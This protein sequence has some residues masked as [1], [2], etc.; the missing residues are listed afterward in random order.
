MH[1]SIRGGAAT[2]ITALV[3]TLL[4]GLAVA[5]CAGGGRTAS[6]TTDEQHEVVVDGLRYSVPI[7]RQLNPR[8]EPDDQYYDGP[9]PPAGSGL[10]AAFIRVCNPTDRPL[11]AAAVH[12]EDAFGQAFEPTPGT[13]SALAYARRPIAPGRCVP[14]ADAIDAVDGAAAVWWVPFKSAAERPLDLVIEG[15][16]RSV[17]I[18]L[19]L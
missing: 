14:I 2:H 4:V 5:A 3:G 12:L 10:Y 1:K 8:I 18:E 13:D 6:S 16:Q 15:R 9:M 19:D 11:A 17:R 7:F